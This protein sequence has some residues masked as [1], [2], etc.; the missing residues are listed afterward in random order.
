[1]LASKWVG[2]KAYD[3]SAR[4][5]LGCFVRNSEQKGSFERS[6]KNPEIELGTT[7]C[8][9][10]SGSGHKKSSR[11]RRGRLWAV[12]FGIRSIKDLSS[13][14]RKSLKSNREPRDACIEVGSGH[15]ANDARRGRLW[16]VLFGIRSRKDLSSVARKILNNNGMV[17]KMKKPLIMSVAVSLKAIEGFKPPHPSNPSLH[18]NADPQ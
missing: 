3:S 14:A 7:R 11:A 10:R 15:K 18:G 16:A 1:M 8:L 2:H 12:L 17:L 9:H 5:A 13:A 6:E 4:Q